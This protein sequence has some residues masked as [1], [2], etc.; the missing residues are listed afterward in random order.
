MALIDDIRKQNKGTAVDGMSDWDLANKIAKDQGR[1]PNAVAY[2]LGIDVAAPKSDFAKEL[3]AGGNSYL[4][5][6]GHL[7][8]A[9]TGS[10]DAQMWA[11]NKSDR[12]GFL[13]G[14]SNAPHS[15]G[16]M[17][18]GDSDKGLLNYLG[19]GLAGS[20][21]YIGEAVATALLP[22]AMIPARL[23]RAGAV[24][25]RMIGGGAL[26]AGADIATRKAALARGNNFARGAMLPL[27]S[28]AS[29][30]GDILQNQYD[31][32][33][34]YNLGYA[35]PMGG[36]YA[37]LNAGLGLEAAIARR[38][39]DR[40]AT[41]W[42]K[43]RI[44][45]A[46]LGFGRSGVE[47]SISEVGQELINQ[48]GRNVVDDSYDTFGEQ[49][50]AAYKE[51]AILGGLMGGTM[52]G[53]HGVFNKK[54]SDTEPT[55][56]LSHGSDNSLQVV[57]T[58]PNEAAKRI[59]L[60]PVSLGNGMVFH[61]QTGTYTKE[62]TEAPIPAWKQQG[63][64]GAQGDGTVQQVES[65]SRTMAGAQPGQTIDMFGLN[66]TDTAPN[67]LV[68]QEEQ[69]QVPAGQGSLNFYAP[70]V[71]NPTM[72]TQEHID[73]QYPAPR[74]GDKVGAKEA[75]DEPS[76]HWV[77]DPI[78]QHERELS[79]G[80]YHQLAFGKG[81]GTVAPDVSPSAIPT[82]NVSTEAT[83]TNPDTGEAL[84]TAA[85]AGFKAGKKVEAFNMAA[86]ARHDG[87]ISQAEFEGHVNDI[88]TTNKIGKLVPAIAKSIAQS[89]QGQKDATAIQV[90]NPAAAA[91]TDL[92][93]VATAIQ[94]AFDNSPAKLAMWT[95]RMDPVNENKSDAQLAKELGVTRQAVS[96]LKRN[97]LESVL[98]KIAAN[99]GTDVVDAEAQVRAFLQATKPKAQAANDVTGLSPNSQQQ[100][101]DNSEVF[102]SSGEDG[103]TA[104]MGVINSVGGSQR[105]NMSVG[106]SEDKTQSEDIRPSN[107]AM[108]M[109][110]VNKAVH[111]RD[112]LKHPEALMAAID[113]N[114]F[115]EVGTPAFEAI[116]DVAKVHFISDYVEAVDAS[117]ENDWTGGQLSR[118]IQDS[119][120]ETEIKLAVGE[121]NGKQFSPGYETMGSSNDGNASSASQ[122]STGEVR[123]IGQASQD[124]AIDTA[125]VYEAAPTGTSTTSTKGSKTSSKRVGKT[126]SAVVEDANSDIAL[127]RKLQTISKTDKNKLHADTA[128]DYV[129]RSLNGEDVFKQASDWV[130]AIDADKQEK[131]TGA[132]GSTEK[133]VYAS[134]DEDV[135]DSTHIK[136][137]DIL[138]LY[139]ATQ[140]IDSLVV[141]ELTKSEQAQIEKHYSEDDK[142]GALE[143]FK[144]DFVDWFLTEGKKAFH[145]LSHL[146]EKVAK[147]IQNGAMAFMM[148]VNLNPAIP[149]INVNVP[150]T[151]YTVNQ[152]VDKPKVDFK[153]V[154]APASVQ[155][156]ANWQFN[157]HKGVPVIIVDKEAGLT[158]VLDSKGVIAGKT[159]SLTGKMKGDVK[160]EHSRN[161][162]LDKMST[163]DKVTEA[164]EF[165]STREA[166]PHYGSVIRV[167]SYTNYF[168]A[169]HP[170]Y[171][172]ARFEF[173]DLR[174]DTPTGA[175]NRISSSCINIPQEFYSGVVAKVVPV[176][177]KI[178][179]VVMPETMDVE[180]FFPNADFS[181]T[182]VVQKTVTVQ[183]KDNGSADV[184]RSSGDTEAIKQDIVADSNMYSK[185]AEKAHGG[186]TTAAINKAIR[187]I[188][189]T[190]SVGNVVVY[191]TAA[192]AVQ[193]GGLSSKSAKGTQAWVSGKTAYF[194]A[195]NI[196]A[197][198]ELAVYLHEVGAHLGIETLLGGKAQYKVLVNK[199]KTW[200]KS[201]EN[202]KE[203]E[204]AKAAFE[205]MS[206]VKNEA[207]WDAELI[208]YFVEEAVKRGVKPTANGYRTALDR[209][210]TAV[211]KAFNAAI[212]KLGLNGEGLTAQNIV[213]LAMGAAKLV[214][215]TDSEI[216]LVNK[217]SAS[218]SLRNASNKGDIKFS[219]S[220]AGQMSK[221]VAGIVGQKFADD[222]SH[223][224]SKM[225][226]NFTQ[227][228]DLIKRVEQ[229][230]PSAAIWY[231]AFNASAKTRFTLERT[232]D[233]IAAM[234]DKLSQT[235]YNKV[236]EFLGDST[237]GQKWGYKPEWLKRDNEIHVDADL[238]KRWNAL[239]KDE[240]AVI[241]AVFKHGEESVDRKHELIKQLG[242]TD[243]FGKLSKLD[244][245]YSPLKRFG[246]YVGILK[247]T[248]L[249]AAEDEL[250]ANEG[251]KVLT[252]KVEALKRNT[253]HYMVSYFG[254]I[255]QA[256]E[257][258]RDHH[259][260]YGFSDAFEKPVNFDDEHTMS[261]VMLRKVMDAVNADQSVP[262]NVQN[263]MR[264]NIQALYLSTL[265]DTN[266]RQMGAKRKNRGGYD[267]D[268][269]RSFLSG[270][271]ADAAYI[272][273][274]EHGG[275]INRAFYG[276]Q[277][278]IK[279]S[280]D[281][282]VAQNE[283]NMLAQHYALNAKYDPSPISDALIGLTSAWQLSTSI[284]YHVQ[285]ALQPI[286]F[287]VPKLAGD[288]N[289]YPGAWKHLMAGYGIV[290]QVAKGMTIDLTRIK[291]AG[292]RA[293]LEN[294]ANSGD[295]DVG[296][297]QD[298]GHMERTRTGY[299]AIDGAS[300]VGSSV[301]HLL[302]SVARTVES[303][304]RISSAVA[305]Y[306]MSKSKGYTE[307]QAQAYVTD[308]LK[309]TQGDFSRPGA[310][311]ILKKLPK[312]TVQ[313]RK[314]Q[315]LMASFYVKAFHA[316]FHG[317]TAKER[318]V[319]KR[320]LGY[321]LFHT[322]VAAGVLG[323]PLMNIA[324]MVVPYLFG[325]DDEPEDLEQMMRDGLGDG[326]LATLLLHG[327][328]AM[329]GLDMKAKLGEQ[330]AFS[331]APYTDFDI[332]SA[333]G[334]GATIVGVAGGPALSQLGRF[335]DGIGLMQSGNYYKG[336]EK[337]VPK[338]FETAMQ[339]FRMANDGY[340]LKNGDVIV[341]PEDLSA[342]GLLV[343]AMGIPSFDLKEI[344]RDH[345]LQYDITKFY[346]DRTSQIEHEYARA[347]KD[348]DTDVMSEMRDQWIGLQDGKDN[349]RV[350]FNSSRSAIKR[351]PLS[352][353]LKYPSSV[354]KRERKE[355]GFMG[356]RD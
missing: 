197:G 237:V 135:E 40:G 251:N 320:M 189:R 280:T 181:N 356:E 167:A 290:S 16:E 269:V 49:A 261:A 71:K 313:Y 202:T 282:R 243:I 95:A 187:A 299:Q 27:T 9:V 69:G 174:L 296:I 148:V 208:A 111:A 292:L 172:G 103:A 351:Q 41:E 259:K 29:S 240:K 331:I 127:V 315:I 263:A 306:N 239:T 53:V 151:T 97:S 59:A 224:F 200:A 23:A 12:A 255:G 278:E 231:K 89:L 22:E 310:A 249:R 203:V 336:V 17:K 88:A 93:P 318:A 188:T 353:L 333:K 281:H 113:W 109:A 274:L 169:V 118:A 270:A 78:T 43:S 298:L 180:A 229:K 176:S 294:A 74:T 55:D 234:A 206:A 62:D 326:P 128:A 33:G 212:A 152:T 82:T 81:N 34:E 11:R 70:L 303:Y 44:K 129:T 178:Q 110:A 342:V 253:A 8:S 267:K 133:E 60:Q 244:G 142:E 45:N 223:I 141:N 186:T 291:D 312:V 209:F 329:L 77:K 250:K 91:S 349:A 155:M 126:I 286:M 277:N 220:I 37:G 252:E 159:A 131:A 273:N 295:L 262:Q 236:N 279:D 46:G 108:A 321:K 150:I 235:S 355:Q 215:A 226:D 219:K 254:T 119:V 101:V 64:A 154:A 260:A 264:E 132:Q 350:Y 314:F 302:R 179:V 345:A 258:A 246:N 317:A 157:A 79:L 284:G 136:P 14:Q 116:P 86:Q 335:A 123:Q 90:A 204:V 175:D 100:V 352:D 158:Y 248:E 48:K 143:R 247:S 309:S 67:H 332:S 85:E 238:A 80:E 217:L 146:F 245:P 311:L 26:E 272:A 84:P 341:G 347:H 256:K 232:A 124:S 140:D 63:Q 20:A 327:A 57:E 287:S 24:A 54:I 283:F 134:T 121:Q 68:G 334:I 198:D 195:E 18:V 52:G 3:Q 165:S 338:G 213:D 241:D 227:L 10:E 4:A 185:G 130:N 30:T 115:K 337:F 288:F 211:F 276:M 343:N 194:I 289:D 346:S 297:E 87:I 300:K 50:R 72:S 161:V 28:Y 5:G 32:S 275:E 233:N 190:K 322:S 25:P 51:S 307:E 348:G 13:Q 168:T 98:K 83:R 308:I 171:Q 94:K 149:Q 120:K 196:K 75:L 319:G 99:L 214:T 38:G 19:Q 145:E 242:V 193:V 268:M 15:W 2:D 304:N 21:P 117:K 183:G 205:R 6:M 166:N 58:D 147:S 42:T 35:L 323:Y 324:A 182:E 325:S 354:A 305:A 225:V 65:K 170:T 156:V 163:A 218:G 102:G 173:R 222:S 76:G 316:A 61:P 144:E 228:H 301:M 7:A 160:S 164:G 216:S 199:I 1:E 105:G 344:Q 162:E 339:S 92:A 139:D 73:S 125:A 191:N 56:L 285:N 177:G 257:F 138:A 207:H 122:G 66:A 328:P 31:Q 153:D 221:T 201:N 192:E 271:R 330:N 112:M 210:L 36:V 47:E 266:A 230:L 340:T 293:A 137:E 106:R 265:E 96:N 104:S 184:R 39:I 107:N 114:D